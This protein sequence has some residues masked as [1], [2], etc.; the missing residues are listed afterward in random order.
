[1]HAPIFR[2]PRGPTRRTVGTPPGV[3]RQ[4]RRPSQLPGQ[5]QGELDRTAQLTTLVGHFDL[6]IEQVARRFDG[7]VAALGDNASPANH[8]VAG[9]DR[10][11]QPHLSA[12]YP[13][14]GA[15]PIGRDAISETGEMHGIDENCWMALAF[16]VGGVEVAREVIPRRARVHHHPLVTDLIAYFGQIK[17]NA[18]LLPIHDGA[19]GVKRNSVFR[20]LATT[21]P[22][23]RVKVSNVS[24]KWPTPSRVR[25]SGETDTTSSTMVSRSPSTMGSGNSASFAALINVVPGNGTRMAIADTTG[26]PLG[27]QGG[28]VSHPISSAGGASSP[29][30]VLVA[31]S[32]SQYDGL[33]S[34]TVAANIRIR[35]AL[36]TVPAV[37]ASVATPTIFR[38]SS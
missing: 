38:A 14:V 6:Q 16:G 35:A 3:V 17:R 25:F 27:S 10:A 23:W 19:S 33:L 34:R 26:C 29:P 13:A 21:A 36:I 28:G 20:F 11:G 15:G 30:Q 1:M 12:H 2:S 32:A 7:G 8:G 37:L 24:T 9:V 31:N 22:S 5:L 4:R 18:D